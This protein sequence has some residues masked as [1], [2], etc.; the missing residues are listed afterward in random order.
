MPTSWVRPRLVASLT[1]HSFREGTDARANTLAIHRE[2][3]TMADSTTTPFRL[4]GVED[5]GERQLSVVQTAHGALAV[6]LVG[7]EPFAVSNRCR[8]LFASLGEGLITEDGCLQCPWHAARY[9]VRT[10]AMTRGPQGAFKPLAGLVKRTTGARPLK[11]FPV[12][13]R[14]G[15]I[16]LEG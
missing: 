11:T 2:Q 9:N 13:L 5:L 1:A 14:D 15:A 12:V 6:G 16:W 7:G 4:V 8:H 3:T 10:G